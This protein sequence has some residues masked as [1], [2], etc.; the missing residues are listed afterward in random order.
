MRGGAGLIQARW[1]GV[2]GRKRAKTLAALH[3]ERVKVHTPAAVKIQALAR[4]WLARRG[5]RRRRGAREGACVC[6][7]RCW[8]GWGARRRVRPWFE[9]LRLL[10]HRAA[11]MVQKYVRRWITQ[12][13]IRRTTRI[14]IK[15]ATRI[16]VTAS[17]L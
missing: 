14:C 17:S 13:H 7:Q 5:V 16:Q 2:L 9:A 8:R 6:I 1:R 4:G 3:F 15:A 11:V 10:K 12:Q